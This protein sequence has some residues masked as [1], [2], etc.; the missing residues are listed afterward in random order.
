MTDGK[1]EHPPF[2]LVSDSEA[3]SRRLMDVVDRRG[4]LFVSEPDSLD[5]V[6]QMIDSV[7]AVLAIVHV[8]VEGRGRRMALVEALRAAKPLLP[9]LVLADS[10]DSELVLAALRLGANDVIA[11]EASKSEIRERLYHAMETCATPAGALQKRARGKITAIVSA[12]PD[13]DCAILALHLALAVQ[14]IDAR[15]KVLLLDL[16]MPLAD[17]L[18]FLGLRSSYT[19]VDAVRSTR[20]FDETLI[21][22]AF[23]KHASGLTVLAMPED[24]IVTPEITSNDVVVLLN[25][26]RTYYNHVVMNLGGAVRSDFLAL[27]TSHADHVFLLCEQTVHSC[28]SNKRLMEFFEKHQLN[29]RIRLVVDRHLEKQDPSA[30]EIARRLGIPLSTTLPP[31]GI[32]R[33]AMKNSGRTLFEIAPRD[34][35]TLAIENMAESVAAEQPPAEERRRF[36]FLSSL[37]QRKRSG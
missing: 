28:R 32:A 24:D 29:E 25:I 9:V 12:R 17:S 4:D 20:R 19:F 1:D 37:F 33:L 14:R 34:K 30:P 21:E 15:G 6:L 7:G 27:M 8:T 10:L 13:A 36:G 18:L 3:A 11:R 2:L 35:Y 26:L 5:R 16:G 22:S 31:S 23:V